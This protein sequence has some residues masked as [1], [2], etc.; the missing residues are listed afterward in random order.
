MK[1]VTI[2]R[3]APIHLHPFTDFFQG[4]EEVDAVRT[5]FGD[6]TEEV[7]ADLQVEFFS[8]RWA[9]MGVSDVDG[10]LLVSSH[11]LA[12]GP[13]RELYLD[14]IHELVH[15]RQ[16]HEGEDLFPEQLSYPDRP[17]EIEAYEITV[18]EAR[19][20]GLDE[21]EIAEY[22]RVPWMDEEEHARLLDHL[23]VVVP[24]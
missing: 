21:E 17:T 6:R 22:L 18:A 5:I 16:F 9:Y 12:H 7:L 3:D 20:I 24:P 1:A 11:Y 19:R 2:R 10:H 13:E 4:F 8:S 23:G 14:V 15:V